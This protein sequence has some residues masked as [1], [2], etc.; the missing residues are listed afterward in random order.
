GFL[1]NSRSRKRKPVFQPIFRF[2]EQ[3]NREGPVFQ[4]LREQPTD[5]KQQLIRIENRAE[6]PANSIK[7]LQRL[8]L[9]LSRLL[10]LAKFF[11]AILPLRNVPQERA[12]KIPGCIAGRAADGYLDWEF[13]AI[14]VQR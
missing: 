14:A 3:Q 5:S 7:Q 8:G 1:D 4:K 13:A 12:E 10:C 2:V 6:F 9:F 11:L